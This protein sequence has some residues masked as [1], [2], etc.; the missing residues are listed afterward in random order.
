[1][2]RDILIALLYLLSLAALAQK[3]YYYFAQGE[4]QGSATPYGNNTSV[5]QYVQ[6]DNVRLYYEIYGE[7]SPLFVLHGGGVGSPYELGELIDSLRAQQRYKVFV[8]STRGHG[9]SEL[10]HRKMSLQQR[11]K[12]MSAVI[13]Q[14][15]PNQKVSLVGFSDGAYT[16]MSVA[17]H[18]SELVE[19]VVAIGAGTVKAGYMSA[20]VK[21]SDWETA[22]KRF[23]DQ[24]RRLMPEPDR[25]QEFA[26]DYMGY[27]N[28]LNLGRDFFSRIQ[29]PILMMTG[30][31]DDHAPVQ[32][33]VDAYYMAPKAQLSII[34][35]AWH[36]CFLDN[37]PATWWSLKKFLLE[38]INQ[39]QGSHKIYDKKNQYK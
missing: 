36:T 39:L 23:Y 10:G 2:K 24:Q 16:S 22:D 1:M 19:R 15:A 27:W 6:A 7:G 32:T 26:T 9:R 33:V 34:P 17:V 30:D 28:H 31:E 29:C 20:E 5:G 37:F 38:D 8:V 11:A 14:L 3:N 21:V 35:K 18:N 12:D 4:R 13:R 25:W